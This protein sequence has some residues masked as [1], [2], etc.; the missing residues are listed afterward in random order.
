L[1]WD[2]GT[3][4]PIVWLAAA[5]CLTGIGMGV[6]TPASN[7]AALETAP[8]QVSAIAGLRAMFRQS[9]SIAPVSVATA[10]LS[11][12]AHPGLAPAWL[13]AAY[14]LILLAALPLVMFV[15]DHRGKW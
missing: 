12:V 10:L 9:G 5:A 14:A 15:P 6:S 7:N 13:Q 1:A 11:R 3:V 4:S 2:P 8:D